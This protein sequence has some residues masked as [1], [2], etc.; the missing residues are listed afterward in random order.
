ESVSQN[1]RSLCRVSG[2]TGCEWAIMANNRL[3]V[4]VIV[5]IIIFK[6]WVNKLAQKFERVTKVTFSLFIL[7]FPPNYILLLTFNNT[8]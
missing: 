6:I 7:A 4:R 8:F 3:A 5:R 2:R 1:S